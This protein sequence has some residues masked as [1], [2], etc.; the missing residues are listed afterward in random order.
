MAWRALAGLVFACV[1]LGSA[2]AQAP[3]LPVTL[4]VIAF[5][6][7]WNLPVWAAQRQGFFDAQGVAVQL[8]YTPSSANLVTGLFDGRYDIALATIDNFVAY[9]EG[10]G[11]AKIPDNPDFFAFMG[12]DSGFL[13]VMAVP[14]C[15]VL[16]ATSR[17]RTLSVDAMTTGLAF[18]LR[19]SSRGTGSAR[20][21]SASCAPARRPIAIAT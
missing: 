19:D 18:V 4:R 2:D 14:V 11:E 7:G 8:S 20:P 9:Q 5:D 16:R 3:A 17:A 13:A 15:E 21:T 12:V 10:Q 1:L 6:G